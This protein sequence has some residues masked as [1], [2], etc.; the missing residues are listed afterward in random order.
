MRIRGASVI[1]SSSVTNY[2]SLCACLRLLHL[3]TPRAIPSVI[4]LTERVQPRVIA[5]TYP[6]G[7]TKHNRG[8]W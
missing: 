6:T 7:Q 5:I 2:S 1:N 8:R 4:V 3:N